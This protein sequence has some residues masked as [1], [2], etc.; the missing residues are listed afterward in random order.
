MDPIYSTGKERLSSM[1]MNDGKRSPFRSPVPGADRRRFL[2]WAAAWGLGLLVPG[3]LQRLA[4]AEAADERTL[5]LHH[6]FTGETL[7]VVHRPVSGYDQTTLEEV[8]HLMRDRVTGGV[9]PI[10]PRLLDYLYAV[11]SRLG[12]RKAFH[13]NSGYR[14]RQTNARLRSAGGGAVRNSYHVK[15]QAVD[16]WIPGIETAILQRA[17]RKTRAGGVGYYPDR[18]FVHLDVGPVRYWTTPKMGS[19]PT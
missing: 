3:P 5:R 17:A 18:H 2:R 1:A 13:I 6:A 12:S 16:L 11:Q 10:D 14:S 8:S 7:R 19:N 9:K 15:G 4:S